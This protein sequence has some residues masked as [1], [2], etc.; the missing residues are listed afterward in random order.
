LTSFAMYVGSSGQ[1][2]EVKENILE[3]QWVIEVKTMELGG[4]L[5]NI[6]IE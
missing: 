3:A 2:S 1:H 5:G 6:K 4:S